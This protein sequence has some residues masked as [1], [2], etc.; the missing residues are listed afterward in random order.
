MTVD[1]A[2]FIGPYPF[3]Y[4]DRTS[5]ADL[6]RAMDRVG[7][8]RAWVGH[9]GSF[10]YRDPAPA[11]A[12]LV[13]DLRPHT[14]RLLPVP[15]VHP[16][17]PDIA[18][19]LDRACDVGAPAVRVYPNWQGLDP[20]GDAMRALAAEAAAR[21][22]PLVLTVRFED[23]RQRHPLD[24]ARDLPAAAV[25]LLARADPGVRL[26]VTHADRSFVEEVH[27][28]L[29]PAEARRVL[30]DFS[31]IWGPPEDHFRLLLRT[32]GV[33]R[34]TLGTGVPLRLPEAAFAKLELATLDAPVASAL[35]A[36]NL[37]TW[38]HG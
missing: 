36:G 6:L 4:V 24:V 8:E 29:T 32:V 12:T 23:S 26:L 7:I 22:L 13:A 3:R 28:G 17:L 37:H 38:M 30:W 21:T 5:P 2:A 18:R 33:E 1:V 27:F 10:L 11:N 19:D 16:G 35:V 25:R 15:T 9:L 34:F 20:A 14:G 31:W